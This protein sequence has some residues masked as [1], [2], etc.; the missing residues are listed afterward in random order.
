MS[1]LFQKKRQFGGGR[2]FAGAIKP[3]DQDP[4]GFLEMERR[5]VAS[6]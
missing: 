2:G 1:L 5:S 4:A 6:E 3:D